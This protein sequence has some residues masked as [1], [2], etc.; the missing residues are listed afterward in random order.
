[1]L[2]MIKSIN[3]FFARI[4]ALSLLMTAVANAAEISDQMA[5]GLSSFVETVVSVFPDETPGKNEALALSAVAIE[6]VAFTVNGTEEITG[7]ISNRLILLANRARQAYENFEHASQNA[8]GAMS[9]VMD[10]VFVRTQ[11]KITYEGTQTGVPGV[12]VMQTVA[13][14]IAGEDGSDG[15]TLV[16]LSITD[17]QG[18][19][20][21]IYPGNFIALIDGTPDL[22]IRVT[23][24][25]DISS[26]PG[27]WNV[28]Y[29]TEGNLS[30]QRVE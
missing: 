20:T 11:G 19:Y 27:S 23:P 1:M 18:D 3:N 8:S 5:T 6:L 29:D 24:V 10:S 9:S 17:L 7:E 22:D 28:S 25:F 12:L 15:R 2:K 4:I 16:G 30:K 26:S 13:G 14:G 21:M